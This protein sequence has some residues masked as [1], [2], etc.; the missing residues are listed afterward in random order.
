MVKEGDL[1]QMTPSKWMQANL[2]T[3]NCRLGIDARQ[4][5]KAEFDKLKTALP[6]VEVVPL[7]VNPVD[8]VWKDRPKLP[9]VACWVHPEEIAGESVSSKLRKL[10]AEISAEKCSAMVISALDEQMWM[11]NIR[12]GDILESPVAYAFSIVTQEEAVL[13]LVGGKS[14]VSEEVLLSLLIFHLF[15]IIYFLKRLFLC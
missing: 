14:R 2:P 1:D 13:Y 6:S 11:F 4:Y 5:T 8:E 15:L 12:G 3:K 7:N 9:P 10:R